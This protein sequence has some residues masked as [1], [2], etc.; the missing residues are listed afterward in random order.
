MANAMKALEDKLTRRVDALDHKQ[1]HNFGET[2]L[3]FNEV[4]SETENVCAR[5]MNELEK[6][7]DIASKI[8]QLVSNSERARELYQHDL[9]KF[10]Q[11]LQTLTD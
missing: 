10:K 9:E 4:R 6:V 11:V 1:T 5:A 8:Q 2:T 3:L 7:Q